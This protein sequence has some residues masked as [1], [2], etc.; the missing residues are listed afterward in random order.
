MASF[1]NIKDSD[2]EIPDTDLFLRI[3][4]HIFNFKPLPVSKAMHNA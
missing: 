4:K 2:D 3:L 1:V